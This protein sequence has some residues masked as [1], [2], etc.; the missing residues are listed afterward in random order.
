MIRTILIIILTTLFSCSDNNSLTQDI[1][2]E[3][4]DEWGGK[5]KVTLPLT[6]YS[7]GAAA[8]LLPGGGY[9]SSDNNGVDAQWG[10]FLAKSGIAAFS[11]GYTLPQG[12]PHQP[13]D[14]VISTYEYIKSNAA[15]LSVNPDSIGII[16]FSAGG[17]LASVISTI[18]S[19]EVNLNFQ[20]LFY[21]VISMEDDITHLPS[22]KCLLGENPTSQQK[23]DFSTYLHVTERTPRCLIFVNEEDHIVP[24]QNSCLYKGA[25]EK[26]WIECQMVTFPGAGH[27]WMLEQVPDRSAIEQMIGWI[28][29]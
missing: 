21:P 16:G 12:N 15:R 20:V 8:I 3:S 29:K 4:F 28:K 18:Y 11:L 26:L 25:L 1:P 23:M 22:Q 7:S 5:L 14:D 6:E 19:D 17:H 9:S 24:F 13:I 10:Q 2:V 27:G